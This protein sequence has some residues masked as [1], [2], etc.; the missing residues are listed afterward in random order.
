MD[1]NQSTIRIDEP[2]RT[3]LNYIKLKIENIEC[4]LLA[5]SREKLEGLNITFEQSIKPM[6]ESQA[7][8]L[9][10]ANSTMHFLKVELS[11]ISS[12]LERQQANSIG[13]RDTAAGVN[14]DQIKGL[15]ETNSIPIIEALKTIQRKIDSEDDPNVCKIC[16]N[17]PITTCVVPCGHLFCGSCADLTL[18]NRCHICRLEVQRTQ[19]VYFP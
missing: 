12:K 13:F 3:E 9:I 14:A 1:E 7:R 4:Q 6:L 10:V 8:K 18:N 17:Q 5:Q 11:N 19:L 16:M 15:I 2:L